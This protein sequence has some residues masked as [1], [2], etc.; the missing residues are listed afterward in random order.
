MRSLFTLHYLLGINKHNITLE[1]MKRYIIIAF[2]T[3]LT[4]VLYLWPNFHPDKYVLNGYYWQWDI[5]EHS[6]YFFC[7]T[8]FC[9]F[10]KIIK[11]KDWIFFII[12]FSISIFLELLQ[13]FIPLRSVDLMDLGSNALG[14]FTGLLV[15]N[16]YRR[17]FIK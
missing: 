13:M 4:L 10:L 15:F 11:T 17:F 2:T 7:L 12:L 5:V 8:L 9:R 6:G 16:M 3:L 14:I 1:K